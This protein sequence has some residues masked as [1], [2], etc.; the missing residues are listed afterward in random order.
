VCA[1]ACT[2]AFYG[3]RSPVDGN[4]LRIL[5]SGAKL[6]FHNFAATGFPER[7]YT[8]AELENISQESQQIMYRNLMHLRHVKAP[9]E[10]LKLSTG[11]RNEDINFI[12]EGDALEH[13][14]AVLNRQTGKLVRPD[15]IEK[16][17]RRTQP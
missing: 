17:T 15:N 11:T 3:G 7:A 9:L 1:S 14:I 10:V 8:K 2:D 6:G 16:R 5:V 12:S 13:G 4:P